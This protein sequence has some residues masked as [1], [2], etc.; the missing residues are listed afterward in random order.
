MAPLRGRPGVRRPLVAGLLAASLLFPAVSWAQGDSLEMTKRRELEQIQRQARES[1][2]AAK[3]LRGRETKEVSRLHL[4]ERELSRTQRRIRNL[5]KRQSRLDQDLRLTRG[6]L[7][8]SRNAYEQQRRRL[9]RRLRNL[10]KAGPAGET[11]FLLST[12]SFAQLLERWDFLVRIA[13]QDRAQLARL[14]ELRGRVASNEQRLSAT[15]DEVGS[16]LSQTEREKRR[17]AQLRGARR[18]TVNEI[19]TQRRAYEAAAVELEKTARSIQRLLAQLE[20]QR[21]AEEE[22]RRR[23]AE[24]KPPGEVRPAP[25]TGQFARAEGS[26]DWPVRGDLVGRFGPE[27][28]PRFGTKTLNNGVDIAAPSGTPVRAVAKGRVDFT[29]EDY[30]TYGQLVI[31]NHGD[32]Y[33]T[34][35]AHLSD[36]LVRVGQEVES[37]GTIGRV[38]DTGSLKGNILHFEVRRGAAALDPQDWLR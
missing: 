10:Y 24:G 30:G 21:K 37:G 35:Y 36:I 15:L 7:E 14:E 26:L 17:L 11:E 27:A 29:S 20:R 28:H 8:E 33:Y 5:G 38:G 2:E 4:T 31:L 22:A 6:R 18:Q 32:G 19:Q 23:A 1:R 25:Y 12:N 34:L 13:R 9:A 3:K 16:N